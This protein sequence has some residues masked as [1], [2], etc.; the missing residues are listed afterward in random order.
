MATA[1]EPEEAQRRFGQR[2]REAAIEA[3][4]E[5]GVREDTEE[6]A[7]ASIHV[8]LA[9]MSLGSLLLIAGV[10]MLALPGPGWITIFAGLAILSKDVAWAERAME[11]VRRH[12]PEGEEGKVDK[13][14]V[15][16]SLLVAVAAVGCSIWWYFLR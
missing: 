11:R 15:A 8:R 16:I 1:G 4:Y 9:R 12:L 3:E 6:E 14:V 5:T 7:R 13:R 10:L 2:L